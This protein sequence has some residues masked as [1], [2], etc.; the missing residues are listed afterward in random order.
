MTM[1]GLM[2]VLMSFVVFVGMLVG[3]RMFIAFVDAVKLLR[4]E[5]LR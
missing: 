4:R 5:F 1:T 3:V 2:Q